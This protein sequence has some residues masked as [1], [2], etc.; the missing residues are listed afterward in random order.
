MKSVYLTT[1]KKTTRGIALLIVIVMLFSLAPGI[2]VTAAGP[3]RNNNKTGIDYRPA[4]VIVRGKINGEENGA[5]YINLTR[6]TLAVQADYKISAYSVN[7]GSTWTA[8]KAG[9]EFDSAAMVKLFTKDVTIQ[10]TDKYDAKTR[11]PE[12]DA[13]VVKFAKINK[14]PAA[15][16]Y[17]VNYLIGADVTGATPGTWVLAEK[18]TSTASIKEGIE[19][20]LADSAGK[21]ADS[22]G[23]GRFFGKNGTKNGIEIAPLPADKK[24][25]S[26]SYFYRTAAK[27]NGN[28]TYTLASASKKI[29]VKGQQKP[30]AYKVDKKKKTV[31]YGANTH[32]AKKGKKA[33]LKSAKGDLNIAEG[34][35][36][37]LWSAA[38]ATNPASAMTQYNITPGNT[39]ISFSET[40]TESIDIPTYDRNS[41]TDLVVILDIHDFASFDHDKGIEVDGV[42]LDKKYY[43]VRSG[44]T[45]ITIKK[46]Y[47]DTLDDGDHYVRAT[48]GDPFNAI[49]DTFFIVD[50]TT[51]PPINVVGADTGISRAE[52]IPGMYIIGDSS[53]VLG[54]PAIT[55]TAFLY[56]ANGDPEAAVTPITWSS[57]NTAIATVAGTSNTGT[58]T[59]GTI[60]GTVTIRAQYGLR[61]ATHVITVTDNN[62]TGLTISPTNLTMY[63]S[64]TFPLTASVTPSS[65][66]N[67]N[68]T[69]T[70]SN[71]SVVIIDNP[72]SGIIRTGSATGSATITA[73]LRTGTVQ[74]SGTFIDSKSC[75]VTVVSEPL[76]EP[77]VFVGSS[78]TELLEGEVGSLYNAYIGATGSQPITLTIIDGSLPPGLTLTNGLISGIPTSWNKNSSTGTAAP[79]IFTVEARNTYGSATMEYRILIKPATQVRFSVAG[80]P[81]GTL[82]AKVNNN[83]PI[84]SG[85]YVA[86]GNNITFT[87]TPNNPNV[88]Y[89]MEWTYETTTGSTS[90]S[91][92]PNIGDVAGFVYDVTN[93]SADSIN[94]TV[95]FKSDA[96]V[97]NTPP[98]P[99]G[100]RD[101]TYTPVTLSAICDTPVTWS[102]IFDAPSTAI[103]PMMNINSGRIE[104]IPTKSGL[105]H[106]II[107]AKSQSQ[108]STSAPF[109]FYVEQKFIVT[110]SAVRNG[111]EP[112][113]NG[114]LSAKTLGTTTGGNYP[115][116]PIAGTGI[117]E[118][119]DTIWESDGLEFTAVPDNGYEVDTWTLTYTNNGLIT[120]PPSTITAAVNLANNEQSKTLRL[121]A[122]MLKNLGDASRPDVALTDIIDVKV[123]FKRSEQKVV[124]FGADGGNGSVTAAVNGAT[125]RS[126]DS[127][128]AGATIVFT[129]IPLNDNFRV[130]EWKYGSLTDIDT[131]LPFTSEKLESLRP[132]P[133]SPIPIDG[134]KMNLLTLSA[135]GNGTTWTLNAMPGTDICVTVA[136]TPISSNFTVQFGAWE[137]KGGRVTATA[138]NVPLTSNINLVKEGSRVVFTAEPGIGY[139]LFEWIGIDTDGN[140]T[141]L[142]RG[143]D[144]YT[145]S[146]LSG[147]L[148]VYARF[149]PKHD[150]TDIRL[151][152][153]QMVIMGRG[154]ETLIPE[155]TPAT[156]PPE[157]ITWEIGRFV[158]VTG[159]AAGY[160]KIDNNVWVYDST[161]N[162]TH[163]FVRDESYATVSENGTVTGIKVAPASENL[164]IMASVVGL[165]KVA[166]CGV[167]VSK[168]DVQ[169]ITDVPETAVTG[170]PLSIIGMIDPLS[171]LLENQPA[172]ANIRI[173]WSLA[174]RTVTSGGTTTEQIILN[175]A[176]ADADTLKNN[177]ILSTTRAGQVTIRAT[178]YEF[179]DSLSTAPGVQDKANGTHFS[180]GIQ[181]DVSNITDPDKAHIRQLDFTITV[182][183]YIPVRETNGITL[184]TNPSTVTAKVPT[185]LIGTVSPSNASYKTIVWSID[186]ANTT[187][188]TT[189]ITEGNILTAENSGNVRLLATIENGKELNKSYTQYIN[190]TVHDIKG[191]TISLNKE[192]LT[193]N[194]G[195][196]DTS[197]KATVVTNTTANPVV[198]WRSSNVNVAVV[199]NSGKIT[200]T[201]AGTATIT[202]RTTD[203]SNQSASCLVTVLANTVKPTITKLSL[204]DGVADVIYN[205]TLTAT[206]SAPIKWSYEGDLPDGLVLNPD[207]GAIMGVPSATK[208]FTFTVIATNS[209]GEDRRPLTIKITEPILVSGITL[210]SEATIIAMEKS[211]LLTTTIFPANATNKTLIWTTSNS[212]VATVS[213]TGI[214]TGVSEGE[215]I[216]TAIA[217]DGGGAN[218][219]CKVTVIHPPVNGVVMNKSSTSIPIGSSET[220]IATVYPANAKNR[221]VVW[222]TSSS[223]IATVKDG[224]VIA[225]AAGTATISAR[226][227]EG[228]YIATCVV[229]VT[230]PV[231]GVTLNKTS[232]TLLH[233]AKESLAANIVPANATN[234]NVTWSTSDRTVAT[235]DSAGVVTAVY[236]G[237]ANITVTTVDGGRMAVC[238]VTVNPVLVTGVT[239]NKNST[240]I[241][242]GDTE[243]LVATIAPANATDKTIRWTSS[244]TN[245]AVVDENGRVTGRAEGMATITATTIDGSFTASCAATVH[246]VPLLGISI[247]SSASIG[248]GGS[249][250]LVPTFIPA[251]ATNKNISWTSSNTNVAVADASG[252]VTGRAEGNAVITVT[253]GEGG[254]TATCS[255]T[256]T[257]PV[258]VTGVRLNKSSVTLT[259]GGTETLTA[260]LT[261]ANAAIKDVTWSSS[262]TSVATVSSNGV[263]TARAEGTAVI[264]VRTADKGFTAACTVTVDGIYNIIV[265]QTSGGTASA[266][267]TQARSGTY[268]TMT[269]IPANDGYYVTWVTSPPNIIVAGNS[270]AM[271]ASDVTITP[272]Y[273]RISLI[274]SYTDTSSINTNNPSYNLGTLQS[275]SIPATTLSDLGKQNSKFSIDVNSSYGTYQVPVN[276]AS[277]IPDL[278]S[279]LSRNNV[280]ISDAAFNIIMQDKTSDRG[281]LDTLARDMP[282]S[283]IISA[284]EF[285]A[286]I[287]T[288][289]SNSSGVGKTLDTIS[290]FSERV[291]RLI[292]MPPNMTVMPNHW[293]VFRYNDITRKFEF[294]PHST[295]TINGV[296][297]AVV[298]STENGIYVVAEHTVIFGDVHTDEW[299]ATYVEKAAA[300]NIVQG[301]GGNLYEPERDVTR[302]E[303]VQ[304]IIRA[305]QLPQASAAA[306]AYADVSLNDWY[307]DAVMKARSAGLLDRFS[308]DNFLP[309]QPITR[310][311]MSVILAAAA[312]REKLTASS[313][314]SLSGSFTDYNQFN[315]AYT[316]DAEFVYRLGIMQGT[317]AGIFN[318]K[319]TTT[320][321][322][323]A[324]VLIRLLDLLGFID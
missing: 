183:D 40:T 187:T 185:T 196:T 95:R 77:P 37:Y 34:G 125:I 214:V 5:Y 194:I 43:D 249:E 147:D 284:V 76:E 206:G 221:N 226:S 21:A 157:I 26:T 16:T 6:E 152:K 199:D 202:A 86:H 149:T 123:T 2:A 89:T 296:L 154:S 87:A 51:E 163:N 175:T 256:V 316:S 146:Y 268:V 45:I 104:G 285:T 313:S 30:P 136:F 218:V 240:R 48:F 148:K 129:A 304:M 173:E 264:T 127:V 188:G 14:R 190:I 4:D 114:S 90:G 243:T 79:Y 52:G 204:P 211:A 118:L 184:T 150:V 102:W 179:G 24:P 306:K 208:T 143:G 64:S 308:G 164:V 219:T 213:Q 192:T 138:D 3:N 244:N 91:G 287:A 282:D 55:L 222:S 298:N 303:F 70:T 99:P 238:A 141:L 29:T 65:S 46:A 210:H 80:D 27:D 17:A 108:A 280:K 248:V 53:A 68:I 71:S 7:N 62:P 41:G 318:P 1:T 107:T 121:T 225:V 289:N 265:V 139:D 96:P 78:P 18:N 207:T 101:V 119:A 177:N 309:D 73:T 171:A 295:Q 61:I 241:P 191:T 314:A 103:P 220:L 168:V 169:R 217:A 215:A 111:A 133:L 212:G 257:P 85:D 234:K 216:I 44:S 50:D 115:S 251:N 186:Y 283:Q 266:T 290:H 307:Y 273:Q 232:L 23:Y 252:R 113:V 82:V 122:A 263:V 269:G 236:P 145:V 170:I 69:W 134:T 182:R 20:A 201:G 56:D 124:V 250:I 126:G 140:E 25:V 259:Q 109:E 209:V 105:H 75:F 83:T 67:Y 19:I 319:G 297:Y 131:G 66:S 161:G 246:T 203:G 223:T 293:G 110:H 198:E 235:V 144:V 292:P 42:K 33:E 277:I 315:S 228:N 258:A 195:E 253:T 63:P 180:T 176:N 158:S 320:R 36:I 286:E 317:A 193:L 237:K 245:V 120:A 38:T 261:P 247:R 254:F 272:V 291:T 31:S 159:G 299:Y 312:R 197:L 112:N 174:T 12:K 160:Y 305:L 229:T 59:L 260:T 224:A 267:H 58:V 172:N 162:G 230:I 49:V 271:P 98:L 165:N 72:A 274:D 97:I 128:P 276:F 302:A 8:V 81:L 135:V 255:V 181:Q 35:E 117:N 300:K 178:I 47:L 88:N 270:F 60:T 239:L 137:N 130:R 242:I 9:T 279:T 301:I 32:I 54:G 39:E 151:N 205:Q 310:E 200:A 100:R 106:V 13:T 233:G 28:G 166:V 116:R 281:V 142:Q 11:K 94:I 156:T 321:A 57:D 92:D 227:E 323:A 153:D 288:L 155:L 15:K 324:T 10:L 132:N 294:V 275:V 311:E 278:N 74:G 167:S 189:T 322:Q 231:T 262:D 22:Q 93:L 84:N